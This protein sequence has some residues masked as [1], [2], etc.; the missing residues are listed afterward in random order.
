M[1]PDCFPCI[2]ESPIFLPLSQVQPSPNGLAGLMNMMP[3]LFHGPRTVPAA[4]KPPPQRAAPVPES[5]KREAA[6]SP[7]L[8]DGSSQ[9]ADY[10]P[11]A[12]GQHRE[13]PY[14]HG[15]LSVANSDGWQWRKYGEKIVKGNPN[16]RSYYK[17]SDAS[18]KAKKIVERNAGGDIISTQYKEEHK[19]PAP[20]SIKAPRFKPRQQRQAAT[21]VK[22]EP[23]PVSR[24]SGTAASLMPPPATGFALMGGRGSTKKWEEEDDDDD[25]SELQQFPP[26]RQ[27]KPGG[28]SETSSLHHE[29]E[30]E[31]HGG[32][33]GYHSGSDYLPVKRHCP[34]TTCSMLEIGELDTSTGKG[35]PV[36]RLTPDA[37]AMGKK[38]L[39]LVASPT[40]RLDALAATTTTSA[41]PGRHPA[42]PPAR[43]HG[44]TTTHA[45]M[46]S[47]PR[48]TR[49]THPHPS[50]RLTTAY[51]GELSFGLC[52]SA[53]TPEGHPSR[54][55]RA[56]TASHPHSLINSTAKTLSGSLGEAEAGAASRAPPCGTDEEGCE[57][58]D[59]EGGMADGGDAA[60][61]GL[62]SAASTQTLVSQC[63]LED[64]FKWRKYGQ[65]H[66]RRSPHPRSYYKCTFKDCPVK[67]HVERHATL[68][69]KLVVTV[70]GLTAEGL[71]T[72][73]HPDGEPLRF[74][75][76]AMSG[77]D[78]EQLDGWPR[79]P[80]SVAP[81]HAWPSAPGCPQQPRP[82]PPSGPL[83]RHMSVRVTGR[84]TE[85]LR[86]ACEKHGVGDDSA[87]ELSCEV[88]GRLPPPRLALT[89]HCP[90]T[91]GGGEVDEDHCH[92]SGSGLAPGPQGP[93][94]DAG[95]QPSSPGAQQQQQQQQSHEQPPHPSQHHLQLQPTLQQV[96]AMLAPYLPSSS[97]P[98]FSTKSDPERSGIPA[99]S[100]LPFNL[101]LL[102]AD[103]GGLPP[104]AR[105]DLFESP[106]DA[107]SLMGPPLYHMSEVP[108]LPILP[109][110]K[111]LPTAP[112]SA[113]MMLGAI[114][115]L[116]VHDGNVSRTTLHL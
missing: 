11:G 23:V 81:T 58:G 44:C 111:N 12:T 113:H 110:L 77:E 89:P 76:L 7:A 105:S 43:N 82:V 48:L 99:A 31:S 70:E 54:G 72:H 88:D 101:G 108:I 68:A 65:K 96:Q 61:A 22:E 9:D 45:R 3:P 78:G 84:A 85:G 71:H 64:G 47:W 94:D 98:L 34:E 63:E 66:V 112:A 91:C 97:L 86:V 60:A 69:D 93:G 35:S 14:R 39:S 49:P 8:A 19:H 115:P 24:R 50:T 51:A 46:A 36:S 102:G 73:K 32:G 52:S 26:E 107:R 80:S 1:V 103:L 29:E 106:W 42:C 114:A 92:G 57:D 87:V 41:M 4:P 59:D 33:A 104:Q 27:Q 75:S 25:D 109:I 17:C 10:E 2:A 55:C 21:A 5:R 37:S 53:S 30:E 116:S 79:R 67:K 15:K 40:T 74:P 38:W 62:G 56:E 100:F 16:P 28:H 90:Y 20:S 95:S 18:C 83:A 6:I 13:H